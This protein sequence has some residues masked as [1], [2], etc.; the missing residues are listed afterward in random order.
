MEFATHKNQY[1]GEGRKVLT[2]GECDGST[3]EA[4]LEA[5]LINY[6]IIDSKW[7]HCN[8]DTPGSVF[9]WFKHVGAS[10]Y[11]PEYIAYEDENTRHCG[12]CF[13]DIDFVYYFNRVVHEPINLTRDLDILL[14][15]TMVS[16]SECI[17]LADELMA[18]RNYLFKHRL[19]HERITF[20]RSRIDARCVIGAWKTWDREKVALPLRWFY[21]TP[22]IRKVLA[23]DDSFGSGVH[24]FLGSSDNSVPRKMNAAAKEN[25]TISTKSLFTGRDEYECKGAD[26]NSD[27]QSSHKCAYAV[28]HRDVARM[29]AKPEYNEDK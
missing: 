19:V 11:E 22:S 26:I 7:S 3:R 20:I 13:H 5:Q 28:I 24:V 10:V 27:W 9:F 2:I 1:S 14:P 6:G 16:G 23:L 15:R 12:V 8:E 17:H 25:G 21:F 4:T 18:I 29:L